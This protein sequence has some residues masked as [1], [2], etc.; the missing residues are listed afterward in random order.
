MT[1]EL[2]LMTKCTKLVIYPK[3]YSIKPKAI[4]DISEN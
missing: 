1:N 4:F 2:Y 3:P